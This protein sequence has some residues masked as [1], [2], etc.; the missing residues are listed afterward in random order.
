[1]AQLTPQQ[2]QEA[3][4]LVASGLSPEA[5]VARV[6][7]PATPK[8]PAPVAGRTSAAKALGAGVTQ[9]AMLGFADELAGVL[10]AAFPVTAG[11][12]AAENYRIGRDAARE[13]LEQIKTDRPVLYGAG[14]VAGAVPLGVAVA[15]AS[16]AGM[17]GA[18][19]AQG[20]IAGAGESS[21]DT[22]GEIAADALTGGAIGTGGALLGAGV[23]GVAKKIAGRS[24]KGGAAALAR[25][26]DDMAAQP[27]A[28]AGA[29]DNIAPPTGGTVRTQPLAANQP[30]AIGRDLE[31]GAAVKRGRELEQIAQGIYPEEALRFRP[32]QLTGDASTA[33]AE[34]AALQIAGPTQ[35]AAV[36]HARQQARIGMGILQRQAERIAA[37][38]D[39]LATKDLTDGVIDTVDSVF[40]NMRK[41]RST[42]ASP[43]FAAV[44]AAAGGKR[45]VLAGKTIDTL[46]NAADE[47]GASGAAAKAIRDSLARVEEMATGTGR[48]SGTEFQRLMAQWGKVAQGEVSIS[49]DL[50]RGANQRVAAM[51]M[52]AMRDDLDN[53]AD[54]IA[55]KPVVDAIR[56]ARDTWAAHSQAIDELATDTVEKLLRSEGSDA[57]GSIPARLAASKPAQVSAV[58]RVLQKSGDESTMRDL[59]AQMFEEAIR[60]PGNVP[61]GAETSARLG[62]GTLQPGT[63]VTRMKNAEP[64][65]RAAFAGDERAIKAFDET[66]EI[67]QR[68]AY[69]PTVIGSQTAP[70]TQLLGETL[71]LSTAGAGKAGSTF[72]AWLRSTMNNEKALAQAASTVDGLE[73]L[74]DGLKIAQSRERISSRAAGALVATINR[75]GLNAAGIGDTPENQLEQRRLAA[76]RER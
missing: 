17:V 66:L 47:Y 43:L 55:S 3:R 69:E 59:R 76:S 2:R 72:T 14:N 56:T 31:I 25:E 38:P 33:L 46:R 40:R 37:N 28:F 73:L 52:R 7:A 34:R 12:G 1:M 27:S 70:L 62:V 20:A 67:M 71:D 5:A 29:A 63:V 74:R 48:I 75:L 60:A 6:L 54:G 58:F 18:G 51:V 41:V 8:P 32:S 16:I 13:D 64:T 24:V 4:D 35:Q 57:A 30:S 44:D 19:A 39:A 68:L 22:A 10:N 15:P 49:S 23:A 61:R 26:I 50:S 9:G 11:G 45:V 65:L 42:E 36:A 21:G 53:S